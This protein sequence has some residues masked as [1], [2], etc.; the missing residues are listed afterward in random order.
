MPTDVTLTCRTNKQDYPVLPTQQIAYVL[1]DVAAGAAAQPGLPLNL[2]LVLDHSGSMVGERLDALKQAVKLAL[3][4]LTPRDTISLVIFDDRPQVVIPSQPAV[5]VEHLKSLVDDIKDGG[6]TRLSEG[7]ELGLAEVSKAAA[8]GLASRMVLVT[9]GQTWGDE[10]RCLELA[11]DAGRLGV[12]ITALGLGVDFDHRL[13]DQIASHSGPGGMTDWLETP[14]DVVSALRSVIAPAQGTVATNAQ[15]ILRTSLGVTPHQAWQVAPFVANLGVRP[16]SQRDVQVELGD[17]SHDTGKQLL[18]ELL[19]PPR[20]PGVVRIAQAEVRYDL[21]FNNLDDQRAR[22]DIVVGFATDPAL[23]IPDDPT[24][25][26]IVAQVMAFRLQTQALQDADTGNLVGA[27]TRL[28]Q[29]A[30][31]LLALGDEAL[32]TTLAREANHLEQ[33]GNLSEAGTKQLAYSGQR[34]MAAKPA[35]LSP[36][37]PAAQPRSVEQP[38]WQ[39]PAYIPPPPTS[40]GVKRGVDVRTETMDRYPD[41]S[42]PRTTVLSQPCLLRVAVTRQPVAER[43]SQHRMPLLIASEEQETR[44]D[45]LVTAPDFDIARDAYRSLVVPRDRDADPIVFQLIPRAEGE[46]TVKVE[47]FHQWRYVGGVTMTTMVLPEQPMLQPEE[48]RARGRIAVVPG[49]PAPDLTILISEGRDEANRRAYRFK[50][51]APSL[52]FY[53]YP[54][55]EPLIFAGS[56][57]AWMEGLYAELGEMN[58]TRSRERVA[59]TLRTIG[60]DLFE[61]LFPRELKE[62]WKKRIRQQ[63]RSILIVSDEPWIPWEMIRPSYEMEDGRT[64]EDDF[65]CE[66][67]LLARWIAG[68]PPPAMIGMQRSALIVPGQS[69]LRY[70]KD[71]VAFIRAELGNVTDIEPNLTAVWAMLKAGGFQ[72]IHFICHGRFD[73]EKHEQSMLYLQ[74]K[75][76]FKARDISGERRNF[77]KDRP[78]VFLNA[79][80]TARGEESLVGIGSWA[81]KFVGAESGGF[82]GSS[83]DVT[84]ALAARFSQAFYR[85]LLK[86]QTIGEA[87]HAARLEIK[88][89]T[90]PTWLAYALYADPLA[91][92]AF[93]A[94][95]G[96]VQSDPRPADMCSICGSAQRPDAK[97]CSQCGQRI[98]VPPA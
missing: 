76:E 85:S 59:A 46:K 42:L 48:A 96:G 12:P 24:V 27:T 45:V 47:F 17:L 77:G 28:R 26:W 23:T 78:F 44:L 72:V 40:G 32:A 57:T 81:E 11:A 66:T 84:D 94:P 69:G 20:Q 41:I 39:P 51:H 63:V 36:G 58:R 13:L 87:V 25:V 74:G 64:V 7:L 18:V 98:V 49:A 93:P 80:Q 3:D 6:G 83:W 29:A 31:Q 38:I 56:P 19:L 21:P 89:D 53:F 82:L 68:P 67:Y 62:L 73:P 97:F 2:C 71:E 8:P 4:Q 65:L 9:D 37:Q 33:T 1:I 90:D 79:C 91:R 10:P 43:F 16:I 92:A 14:Q 70:A 86:G 61:K 35:S 22:A 55:K 52:G 5:D 95:V 60:A 54:I 34:L 50:L 75:E 88:E 15:L 30:T